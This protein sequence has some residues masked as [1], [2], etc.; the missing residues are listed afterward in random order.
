MGMG[1][2]LALINT[3]CRGIRRYL[4]LTARS[5]VL[6]ARRRPNVLLVQSPSLILSILAVL[7]RPALGYRLLLDA[8]NE[9]VVPYENPQRWIRWLSC[10][11][12]RRADLTIV[13]NRQLA[14]IVSEQ[15]G[16]AFMLPDRIPQPVRSSARTLG[17]GF[18]V[19]LIATFARDEPLAAI[20]EAV[21]G[22]ELELYVTGNTRK[23]TEDLA[24]SAPPNVR[25][26]GFLS[27]EDYWSLLQSVDAVVDLTLKPDCLV[28]GAY[29]AL[30]LGKPLLLSGNAASIELFGEGALFTD[31][32]PS[33]IRQGLGRLRAEQQALRGAAERKRAELAQRWEVTARALTSEPAFQSGRSQRVSAR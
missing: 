32:S 18:N 33:D 6:L 10:W 20:F 28:C 15:G 3:P 30:A 22:A 21:R 7:L 13:T 24:R 29:E 14:Q 2:E 16:R 1:I 19:A 9:A 5:L 17:P 25:F 12:I 8:H 26:T 31:N 11:V 23:L 4:L 27:E